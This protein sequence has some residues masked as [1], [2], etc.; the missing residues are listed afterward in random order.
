MLR[1]PA[2]EAEHNAAPGGTQAEVVQHPCVNEGLKP[3]P[4]AHDAT[5]EEFRSWA[6]RFRAF[7]PIEEQQAYLYMCLDITLEISL[8][9]KVETDTPIFQDEADSKANYCIQHLEELFFRKYPLATRRYNYLNSRQPRGIAMSTFIPTL[10]K[11][12]EEADIAG[13][14][15][16]PLCSCC[17]LTQSALVLVCPRMICMHALHAFS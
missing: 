2:P 8:S 9:S 14:R 7:L 17:V 12:A 1:G 16:E 11:K 6:K 4:L 10:K 15:P 3:K 13:L 5:P